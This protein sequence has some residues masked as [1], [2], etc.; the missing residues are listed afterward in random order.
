MHPTNKDEVAAIL[1]SPDKNKSI[2]PYNLPNN[3]FIPLK[4]EISN[5]LADL[6]ILF[7][8]K[9]AKVPS[10]NKSDSKLDYQNYRPISLL[11]NFEKSL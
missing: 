6:F 7:Y 1:S 9:I 10:V 4:N 2:G 5:T 11:S 3:I 8:P